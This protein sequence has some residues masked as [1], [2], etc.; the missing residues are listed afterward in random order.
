MALSPPK[1]LILGHSF[2][3][4][5]RDDLRSNFDSRADENFHLS[6]DAIV[7]LSGVG[8]RTVRKLRQHDLGV[9]SSRNPT[10]IILDI[11]TNDLVD[12]RPEVVGS[13][14]EELIRLF[15][16]SFSVSV[17]GV[18]EVL[19]RVQAP[20]FNAAASILNQYLNGVLEPIPNV[21][22]W[23]HRGFREPAVHPYLP[24]GVHVN[25]FGQ[26]F[27]YRSYRGAILKA[28]RML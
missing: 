27:L 3:R 2:V 20:F 19:P 14:I 4:R 8:G 25:A 15:L 5:L 24:D 28:L 9:V 26:Y 6:S 17:V 11:G 16:D 13:E 18:C 23:K 7:Y 22:C 10:V 1:V 12:I 21:F